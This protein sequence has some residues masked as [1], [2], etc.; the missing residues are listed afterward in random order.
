MVG[1]GRQGPKHDTESLREVQRCPRFRILHPFRRLNTR[2]NGFT[3]RAAGRRRI[4]VKVE[5]GMKRIRDFVTT[6]RTGFLLVT[7]WCAMA[8]AACGPAGNA[9]LQSALRAESVES[10]STFWFPSDV[11]ITIQSPALSTLDPAKRTILILYALPNGNT[12][13]QTAGRQ[14]REGDNWRFDIQ[15][16][17]AQTRFLRHALADANLITIYLEHGGGRIPDLHGKLSRLLIHCRN[18]FARSI[19][20]SH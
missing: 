3:R 7:L 11:R 14:L 8:A 2:K 5:T 15:H 12:T 13:E 4:R 1:R 16:I 17:A 10:I 9:P 19:R 20:N 6:Q 18:G